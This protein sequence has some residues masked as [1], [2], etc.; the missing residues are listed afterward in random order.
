VQADSPLRRRSSRAGLP[1]PLRRRPKQLEAE[2]QLLE[3]ARGGA[4]GLVLAGGNQNGRA[5]AA[6]RPGSGGPATTA[7]QDA[8]LARE[9]A[10]LGHGRLR[11]IDTYTDVA[12][13]LSA[14][15][16]R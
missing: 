15:F 6:P 3:P 5:P 7:E 8:D 1:L 4:G 14:I 11:R 16:A 2:P 13:A 9:L 10:R 12:P